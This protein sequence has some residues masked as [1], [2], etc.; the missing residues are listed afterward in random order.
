[1]GSLAFNEVRPLD[2]NLVHIFSSIVD[3]AIVDCLPLPA[4][5]QSYEHG[6]RGTPPPRR[7]VRRTNRPAWIESEAGDE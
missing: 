7:P 3:D 1:M 2:G 4:T 5:P 6:R